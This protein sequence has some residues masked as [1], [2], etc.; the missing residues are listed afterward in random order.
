MSKKYFVNKDK[1]EK[2]YFTRRLTLDELKDREK[3]EELKSL[4][5]N[6]KNT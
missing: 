2:I 3:F 4:F 1:K 5:V 6:G